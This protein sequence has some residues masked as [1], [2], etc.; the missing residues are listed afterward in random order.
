M[1][2]EMEGPKNNIR[3]ADLSI[4]IYLLS[5]KPSASLALSTQIPV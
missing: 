3:S 4:Y 5:L 2:E 1:I